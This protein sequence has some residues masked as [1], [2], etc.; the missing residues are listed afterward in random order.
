M[1]TLREVLSDADRAGV[2]VGHFDISDWAALNAV[3]NPRGS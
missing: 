1:K 2:A 3:L